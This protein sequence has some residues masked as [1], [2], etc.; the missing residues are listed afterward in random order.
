MRKNLMLIA[1]LASLVL[2][3]PA[4][5]ADPGTKGASKEAREHMAEMH[6]KMALC[7]RSDRSM[8]ECRNEMMG[9]DMAGMCSGTMGQDMGGM[10]ANPGKAA[11]RSN[12]A[13]K[14][15]SR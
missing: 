8:S 11:I 13:K 1:T 3:I 15:P 2:S 7:L 14:S 4:L 5:A 6:E 9:N 12:T 10:M